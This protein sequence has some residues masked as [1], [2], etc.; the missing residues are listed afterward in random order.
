MPT[1]PDGSCC[2]TC[3]TEAILSFHRC[4]CLS[5]KLSEMVDV[6]EMVLTGPQVDC[7]YSWPETPLE[8]SKEEGHVGERPWASPLTSN[9][10]TSC[11]S[12]QSKSS[13]P[14][15]TFLEPQAFPSSANENL[16]VN[17]S[18]LFDRLSTL[19]FQKAVWVFFFFFYLPSQSFP[20]LF[21]WFLIPPLDPYM[22]P[23]PFSLGLFSLCSVSWGI[24]ASKYLPPPG[25]WLSSSLSEPQLTYTAVH[26]TVQSRQLRLKK[27]GPVRSALETSPSIA[28]W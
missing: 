25:S 12:L 28:Q 21:H 9:L 24:H 13:H 15:H 2:I 18:L 5:A 27:A 11:P 8:W 3:P 7:M 20:A 22:S 10:N 23:S 4:L 17:Q 16:T 1:C 14:W 6:M 26:Q 19:G